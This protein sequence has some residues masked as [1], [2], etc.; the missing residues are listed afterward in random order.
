MWLKRL[1]NKQFK[2][3]LEL[4]T[5]DGYFNYAAYLLADENNVS[6]KVAKYKGIKYSQLVRQ[7]LQVFSYLLFRPIIN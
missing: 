2:R 3:N 6:I 7:F 5:E 1:L 4:L